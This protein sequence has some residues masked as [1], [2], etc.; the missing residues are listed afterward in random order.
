MSDDT[1]KSVAKEVGKMML[2]KKDQVVFAQNDVGDNMY[3]VVKGK[4]GVY[5][6]SITDFPTRVAGITAGRVFGEMAVIDGWPRS[7]TIISEDFSMA[8][9][10]KKDDFEAFIES[11]PDIAQ[12]LLY[13][14]YNR[15]TSIS[16]SIQKLGKQVP[17]MP[18]NTLD[19]HSSDGK[20]NLQSMI[21]IAQRIRELNDHMASASPH[22]ATTA[23]TMSPEFYDNLLPPSYVP[24]NKEDIYRSIDFLRN[25]AA[26]CPYCGH[27]YHE[28]IPMLPILRVKESAA[29]F[30][31]IY[32]DFDI[33]WY[34]NCVCPVC[35]YADSYTEFT[36][37]KAID[38]FHKVDGIVFQTSN[39]FRG[40]ADQRKHTLDEVF[41]SYYLRLQCIE[42]T[43]GSKLAKARTLH[44]IYWL[45]KDHGTPSLA[46]ETARRAY[47]AYDEYERTSQDIVSVHDYMQLNIILGELS[48]V[49][50]D[51]G[52]AREHFMKNLNLPDA[53]KEPLRRQS[54]KRFQELQG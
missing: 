27:E 36:K 37:H 48:V 42:Q 51:T 10:I 33:L 35:N 1:L 26:S 24:Y 6:N 34:C 43:G 30:R 40:F 19:F 45:Y 22:Y 5:I 46:L 17:D 49:I 16:E 29:D 25:K 21:L 13:T 23:N 15:M 50:G 54:A 14:L 53:N 47:V 18:P 38:S 8:L 2:F 39:G 28:K 41:L 32:N 7:A 20:S 3:V 12:E 11:K 4:F 9:S 31:V 52:R 44:R